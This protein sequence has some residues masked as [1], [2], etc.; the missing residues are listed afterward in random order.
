MADELAVATT[1]TKKNISITFN[2]KKR[3]LLIPHWPI[4]YPLRTYQLHLCDWFS[5]TDKTLIND[6]WILSIYVKAFYIHSI[7]CMYLLH[8][9]VF[10]INK[11]INRPDKILGKGKK[12]SKKWHNPYAKLII[13]EIIFHVLVLF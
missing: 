2:L 5:L 11:K 1:T 9:F 7:F 3:I 4:L 13:I 10:Q 6:T 8:V 12:T